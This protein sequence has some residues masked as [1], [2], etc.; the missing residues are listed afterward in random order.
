[1]QEL[2]SHFGYL[3][4]FLALLGGGLGI[5][6]PE[7]LTQLTAGALAH[8]GI[9]RLGVVIPVIWAGIVAGDSVL[10]L[11]ARRHGPWLLTT[12]AARRFLTPARLEWLDR[13]YARH[14]FWTVA[15]ARHAGGLRFAAFAFAGTSGVRYRTFLAADGLSALVSVPIVTLVGYVLWQRLSEARRDLHA[16]QLVLL[17]LVL[18]AIVVALVVRR[19]RAPSL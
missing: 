19:R 16:V 11:I 8:E 6:I 18:V 3:A 13:H 14:A 12:R 15:A 4:V 7:E 17:G 2:I 5:P 10:F 1:V 9:L